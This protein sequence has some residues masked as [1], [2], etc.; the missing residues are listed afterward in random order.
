MTKVLSVKPGSGTRVSET[1]SKWTGRPSAAAAHVDERGQESDEQED[2][3]QREQED[4][5][6]A[7]AAWRGVLVDFVVGAGGLHR[8]AGR[9]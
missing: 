2:S 3:Q 7:A 4:E 6:F 1:L 5:A 9:S 8:D